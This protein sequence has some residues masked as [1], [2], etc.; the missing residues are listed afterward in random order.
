MSLIT[1]K[2]FAEK[3]GVTMPS[4]SYAIRKGLIVLA[5]DKKRIN[6]THKLNSEYLKNK[7]AEQKDKNKT[8]SKKTETT[9]KKTRTPKKKTPQKT[10]KTTKP[11]VSKENKKA[12]TPDKKPET[13]PE[14]DDDNGQLT[15]FELDRNRKKADLEMKEINIQ[16]KQLELRRLSGELIPSK[17]VQ[18]VFEVFSNSMMESMKNSAES[19][20]VKFI[21]Q[22][23]LKSDIGAKMQ[24]QLVDMIN[25]GHRDALIQAKSEMTKVFE[26]A[27]QKNN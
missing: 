2:E 21:N 27:K 22:A 26:L 11:K 5:R 17:L 4:I 13:P 3:C 16:M 19:F 20:R 9:Q 23:K 24:S 15:I 18:A 8:P 6:T 12:K 14:E 1:K 10:T 25:D 7:I